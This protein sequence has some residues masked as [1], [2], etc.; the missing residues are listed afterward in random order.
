MQKH[1]H[2]ATDQKSI[3]TIPEAIDIF[4]H[5]VSHLSHPK[6]R[7]LVYHAKAFPA[8]AD[9]QEMLLVHIEEEFNR[10]LKGVQI[11]ESD[12]LNMIN[13]NRIFE[14]EAP[15]YYRELVQT[16]S[17]SLTAITRKHL[18][19]YVQSRSPFWSKKF[20]IHPIEFQHNDLDKWSDCEAV[21][22]IVTAYK[23]AQP[24]L[25]EGDL[26]LRA[27]VH[28]AEQTLATTSV[29]RARGLDLSSLLVL[30]FD[31]VLYF[32]I[33]KYLTFR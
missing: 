22:A 2:A 15:G 29:F 17:E 31:K 30:F 13:I 23:A 1:W 14:K 25:E 24:V 20:N 3:M 9:M 18:D 8:K 33:R 32:M 5:L 6:G 21:I 27:G 28:G 16:R 19:T 11:S 7:G 12:K 10:I 4:E 26:A